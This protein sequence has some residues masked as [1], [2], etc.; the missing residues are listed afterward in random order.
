VDRKFD[1]SQYSIWK[2]VYQLTVH[3]L[4]CHGYMDQYLARW[5]FN[6][7]QVKPFLTV[8]TLVQESFDL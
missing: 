8:I 1:R 3:A 6:P 4:Q 7:I 5:G 2:T